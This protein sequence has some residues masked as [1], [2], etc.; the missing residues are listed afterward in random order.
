VVCFDGPNDVSSFLPPSSPSISSS[1]L[2]PR[3]RTRSLT[4]HVSCSSILPLSY[5]AHP[6]KLH[7]YDAA[8]EA[9][10]LGTQ[11]TTEPADTPPHAPL[12][13][14]VTPK[15]PSS[16]RPNFALCAV[17][18][19]ALHAVKLCLGER[20]GRQIQVGRITR[21]LHLTLVGQLVCVLLP[22]VLTFLWA[23]FSNP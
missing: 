15:H 14:C 2:R 23:S 1:F 4:T 17:L 7:G 8:F 22:L 3:C 21:V 18:H 5:L 10:R 19:V 6:P 11:P 16:G 20:A 9:S 12:S 13:P